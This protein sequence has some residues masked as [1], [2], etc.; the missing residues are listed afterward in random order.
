[1]WAMMLAMVILMVAAFLIFSALA[2][3]AYRKRRAPTDDTQSLF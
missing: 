2:V 3:A 1:M